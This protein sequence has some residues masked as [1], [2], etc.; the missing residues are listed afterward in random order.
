M[1]TYLITGGSGFIGSH[2]VEKLLK[3]GSKVINLD[4]FNDSYNLN[5]KIRN[6]IESSLNIDSSNSFSSLSLDDNASKEGKLIELKK[7]VDSKQYTLE[8]CDI[9]DFKSISRIFDENKID[10]IIHLAGKSSKSQS[11]KESLL[12]QDVNVNGTQ[13]ILEACKIYGVKKLIVAS[14][15]AVYGKN[16]VVPFR[17]TDH[18][19]YAINPYAATKKSIEIMGHVYHSLYDINML[20]L[21]FFQVY[22]PRQSPNRAINKLIKSI[23]EDEEVLVYGDGTLYND[24]TYIEDALDGIC[25]SINYLDITDKVYEIFNIGTGSPVSLNE[26]IKTIEKILKKES[27]IKMLP[28]QLNGVNRT[29]ADINKGKNIIGYSPIFS[30]EKGIKNSISWLE[31]GENNLK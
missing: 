27:N 5:L 26:A 9:R 11:I 25:K 4:N 30:F 13:N 2:L 10:V 24:Y 16:K 3:D 22:G 20:F 21:R 18:V 31:E 12:Y 15:S 8:V 28:I 19:D 14:S 17:E 29:Y 6:T 23:L 1:K 7:K